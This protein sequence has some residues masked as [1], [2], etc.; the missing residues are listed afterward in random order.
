MDTV[1]TIKLSGPLASKFGHVHKF[2]VSNVAEAA[3]ALCV[4]V[5]GFEKF[6]MESKDRGLEY[7]VLVGK[8]NYGEDQLLNP[9][10]DEREIRIVPVVA[11]SK[12]GGVLQIVAGIVLVAVGIFVTGLTYGWAA[13]VGNALV[14]M[15]ISMIVGG[16]VQLLSPPPKVNKQ[17]QQ[18]DHKTSHVFNGAINVQA[19]GASVPILYGEM[20]TGSVV[21]SAGINAEDNYAIPY[22]VGGVGGG[23]YRGGGS[24][25]GD[26][27]AR[28]K[29]GN[30]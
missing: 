5:P 20:F 3:R 9:I 16:V 18:Q 25:Y 11:G 12:N 19:Q 28:A 7:V 1:R 22:G 2:S 29:N 30:E 13:P 24:F 17:D 27:I 4:M 6:L 15:G 21:V 8:E 10:G 23:R 26:V 14:G